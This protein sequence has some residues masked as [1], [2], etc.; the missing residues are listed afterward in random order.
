MRWLATILLA[1]VLASAWM[2]APALSQTQENEG[3]NFNIARWASGT[4]AYTRLSEPA[5]RGWEKFQMNAYVDGSRTMTMWH[6]LKA[7]NAQFTVILRVDAAFKPQEA[8]LNYWV[9]NG[10]KGST[11][12]RVS[13]GT[14]TASANGPAGVFEQ[15]LDVPG[16]FSIGTHPVSADGWHMA[17]GSDEDGVA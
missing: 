9:A 4:Y 15:S 16:A 11:L 3:P 5:D 13:E 10:F 14:L 8:F 6:D 1:S 12:I 2:S 7:R 17:Q